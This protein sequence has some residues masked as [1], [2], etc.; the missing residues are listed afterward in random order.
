MLVSAV[1]TQRKYIVQWVNPSVRWDIYAQCVV[2][3]EFEAN[4]R[5]KE[6]VRGVYGTVE[7]L[8]ESKV[9]QE[10]MQAM[11]KW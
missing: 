8:V 11:R 2:D 10:M 3:D 7:L 4:E 9:A 1:D 6:K 5:A